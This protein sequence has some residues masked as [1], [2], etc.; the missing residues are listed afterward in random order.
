MFSHTLLGVRSAELL[1]I[2][3]SVMALQV[4]DEGEIDSCHYN[5]KPASIWM[6]SRVHGIASTQ[7][8]T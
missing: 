2:T 4:V 7:P 6:Y 5:C 8:P 1:S 3:A